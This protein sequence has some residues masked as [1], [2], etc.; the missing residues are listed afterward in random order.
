MKHLFEPSFENIVFDSSTHSYR[1]SSKP[2]NFISV[3]TLIGLY[4]QSFDSETVSERVSL[5]TGRDKKEILE[6]W[7]TKRNSSASKG[8]HIHSFIECRLKNKRFNLD[9]N[10]YL[11]EKNQFLQFEQNFLKGKEI[12][13]LEKV[14]YDEEFFLAGTID[15]LVYCPENK[16]LYYIDW[17]TNQKISYSNQY[18][19]MKFPLQK[20]EQTSNFIYGLQL[21]FYRYMIE[22]YII[23]K[24][25]ELS[26]L[27]EKSKNM[28]VQFNKENSNYVVIETSY[29]KYSVVQI[30]NHYTQG[31]NK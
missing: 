22:K 28:I 24:N 6:E 17:K 30:L 18:Q 21:S 2:N 8:T 16:I 5:K 27:L 7:E 10:L 23:T 3:T 9:T 31:K 4:S 25:S 11:K 12:L 20:Y 13:F 14:L 15:C 19:N 29:L 1:V 26:F